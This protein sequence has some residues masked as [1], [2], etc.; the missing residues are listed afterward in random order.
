M[1]SIKLHWIKEHRQVGWARTLT[2][3]ES[4]ISKAKAIPRTSSFIPWRF[5][6][7]R[8]KW[9]PGPVGTDPEDSKRLTGRILLPFPKAKHC[10]LARKEWSKETRGETSP[11]GES[12]GSISSK[13]SCLFTGLW[14]GNA[15]C[16]YRPHS[17]E[18]AMPRLAQILKEKEK[19]KNC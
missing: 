19:E 2:H 6:K 4:V 13:V 18:K 12:S 9:D 14:D 8:S 16:P 17:S 10:F 7:D 15:H 11:A 1:R 3:P 5:D